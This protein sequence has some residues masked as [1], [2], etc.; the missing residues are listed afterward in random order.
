MSGNDFDV[1]I[2]GAGIVG[3]STA[4][5]AQKLG[6]R[7][8]ICDPN[9]PGSGTTSGSAC[10][11]ATYACVPVNS[12]AIFTSLPTLLFSK[13]SP[14]SINYRFALKNMKWMLSFL[15]NCRINKVENIGRE[16]GYLLRHA[17][18]GLDPLIAEANA[19][20]LF[21]SN[22]CLYI[23]STKAGF[24]A[25]A[26]GNRM[27][28]EQ[29]VKY[30]EIG[31]DDVRKLEPAVQ[32]PIHRAL[33]FKGARHVLNP[34]KLV[35]RMSERFIEL[36]GAQFRQ[37]VI[38]VDPDQDGT[39]AHL[40]NGEHVRA[41]HFVLAAGAHGKRIKGAGMEKLPLGVERGYNVIYPEHRSKLERPVG[42]AEAGIYATPMEL[43]LRIAGTVELDEISA[44]PN[45][46]RIEYLR[47]R[48]ND[49]FGALGQPQQEW[50]GFRPTM[51]DSLPVI[52]ASTV[53]D[54][55]FHAYGH[56]HVG[57]TLGGITGKI[58]TDLIR[59]VEPSL[60]L[61][62]LSDKRFAH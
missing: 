29:G 54:R 4:L 19:Q 44:P 46:K 55:V 59:G 9:P 39:T 58:I 13:D 16:L 42:W 57:L 30:D 49:M 24:D 22:D 25:A 37:S 31:A 32:L 15:A 53:S 50:L 20:D 17:D 12:P 6:L 47:N 34:Q 36:G 48:A 21:V 14:L 8:A 56:Q 10:T 62:G 3:M 11:I 60:P 27:R 43:G 40:D 61:A 1:L 35:A 2:A 26:S 23:W 51:P 38:A 41:S 18:A 52:G 28:S 5:W 7:T 45:P 33:L